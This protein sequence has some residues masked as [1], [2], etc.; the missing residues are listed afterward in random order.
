[1]YEEEVFSSPSTL[2]WS[3]DSSKVAFLTLD[4]TLVPEYTFPIYNPSDSSS[5]VYP[6]T[7]EVV[8]K[9]P[10][11]GYPNPIVTV[12]VFE[13]QEYLDSRGTDYEFAGIPISEATLALDWQG[14]LPPD[15]SIL[16]EVSWFGNETL[17]VKEADRSASVGS[18]VLFDFSVS[19][20]EAQG[21][22]VRRLG[23][24]GESDDGG[25]I[26]S[27]GLFFVCKP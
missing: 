11:P 19:G 7:E 18:V 3:P 24:G 20:G 22:V 9:Y 25:W 4:E 16:F 21:S 27:V 1:M 26:D 13:L 14:R 17:I 23:E 2:W 8:M 10:K 6:Y 5:S 12:H 15:E